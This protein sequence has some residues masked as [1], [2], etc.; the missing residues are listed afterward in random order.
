MMTQQSPIAD[1]VAELF[2]GTA[3]QMPEEIASAFATEQK[4][5]DTAGLPDGV[6]TPGTAMPDAELL[7]TEGKPT[8]LG[9]ARGDG[10]SVVVL[11]RGAWCPFCNVTLKTYQEHL[12]PELASRGVP[13]IAISPQRPD[14]SLSMQEKHDLT[15]LVLSDPGNQIAGELGILTAPTDAVVEAQTALGI[16]LTEINADGGRAL[17]M[18]TVAIVDAN[19]VLRWIDVHPNYTTRTEPAAILAALATIAG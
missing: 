4:A 2:A 6:L 16:D 14:G 11:Y 19:G 12:V 3:T 5:L 15:Y 13:L 8:T 18:P 10:A 9:Q 17:P 7:D 1:G